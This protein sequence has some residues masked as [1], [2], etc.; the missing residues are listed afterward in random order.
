MFYFKKLGIIDDN[1]TQW[2]CQCGTKRKQPNGAG[3]SNLYSHIT[4]EHPNWRTEAHSGQSK[5]TGET[6]TGG[7]LY[8]WIKWVSEC[9]LPF[10][11]VDE[12]TTRQFTNLTPICWQTLVDKIDLLVKKVEKKVANILPEKFGLIFDGWSIDS[13]HYVAIFACFSRGGERYTPLLAF[14]PLL[15]EEKLD[16][17]SHVD[18]IKA[19]LQ[20]YEK[21]TTNVIFLVADNEN[22]NNKI[23]DILSV[24]LIGCASHRLNLAVNLVLADYEISQQNIWVCHCK[25]NTRPRNQSSW[26]R[27]SEGIW[28]WT[29]PLPRSHEFSRRTNIFCGTG[30]TSQKTKKD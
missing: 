19:T 6:A 25:C 27:M 9:N 10:T 17:K 5:I 26:T 18:F 20:I 24:S 1:A 3:F 22:T 2:E 12:K 15:D 30:F 8:K 29:N 4:K 16:A 7:N 13:D 28:N 23:S 21:S 11:F 14:S